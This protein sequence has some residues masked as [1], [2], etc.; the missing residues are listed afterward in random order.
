MKTTAKLLISVIALLLFGV[1]VFSASAPQ[2]ASTTVPGSQ[3][4]AHL[5]VLKVF[6][7]KDGDA[8]FR[9]YMVQWK[10]QEVIVEDSLSKTN[11]SIGDTI[12]V[13]VM[14]LPYPHG[15]EAY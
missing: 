12:T 9:A 5:K 13:L 11:Y 4:T 1:S 6:S 10:D 8:I 3:E 7:A 15:K 2:I 14:K